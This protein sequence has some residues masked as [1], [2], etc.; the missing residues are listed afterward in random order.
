VLRLC[1]DQFNAFV[2]W[3]K[4]GRRVP[5]QGDTIKVNFGSS[6]AVTEGWINID[7]S[8]H[9]LFAGWPKPFLKLLYRVSDARNWCGE[10]NSYID[11]LKNYSFVHHNLE[12]QLPFPAESVDYLFSSH[13]LEHFYRDSAERV[14]G[15]IYRVLKKGGLC[16]FCVP[17]LQHAFELY[18]EGQRERSLSYFFEPR[19]GTYNQHRYM[20]DFELLAKLLQKAGFHSIEK[21][22]YRHGMLPDLDRLDNRPDETLYVECLK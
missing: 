4:K 14:V 16:R 20:Y 7:G 15:E 13:V 8:L 12:Y 18:R 22:E 17:D 1:I 10:E 19:S 21:C 2:S 3:A 9:V 11:R 5:L 6:L